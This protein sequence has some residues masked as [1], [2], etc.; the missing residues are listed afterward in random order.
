MEQGKNNKQGKLLVAVGVVLIVI[1]FLADWIGLGRMEGFGFKQLAIFLLGI[2]LIF[3][4][5]KKCK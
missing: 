1:A 5:R 2:I 3:Y 4:G